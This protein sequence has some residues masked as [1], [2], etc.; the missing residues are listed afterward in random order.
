MRLFYLTALM[1]LASFCLA[2]VASAER[3]DYYQDPVYQKISADD[4]HPMEELLELAQKGDPRAQYILGDLYGKGKGGLGK[5]RVKSRYW[6]ETAALNGYS[7]AFI[8]LAAQAKN[9]RDYVSAYKWYTLDVS[10]AGGDERRWSQGQRDKLEEKLSKNDLREAK[11]AANSWRAKRE[12]ERAE[13]RAKELEALRVT[14]EKAKKKAAKKAAAS[15]K[16]KKDKTAKKETK[17]KEFHYND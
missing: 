6:F 2:P 4:S 1:A 11:E 3:I 14:Q 9:A 12:K 15:K 8:R 16:G 17:E 10:D 5:N 7:M 13:R